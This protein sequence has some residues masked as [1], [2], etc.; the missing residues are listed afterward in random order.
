M[1][2]KVQA[3]KELVFLEDEIGDDSF[4]RL[5]AQVQRAELFKTANQESK[6]RLESGAALPLVETAQERVFL[7]FH[8]ALRIQ[9]LGENPRQCALSH[10]NGTFDSNIAGQLEKI[11]HG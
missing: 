5:R 4:L 8:H 9:A 10:A 1:V 2:G 6:L 3:G 11:G 7:G